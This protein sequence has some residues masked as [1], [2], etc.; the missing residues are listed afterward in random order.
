MIG[1]TFPFGK[2]FL[3]LARYLEH[4]EAG[5]HR[6]RVAWVESRNLPT[7]DP[8]T[9]ARL[10][11][12]HARESVRTQRPVYHFVISFDPGDPVDRESMR[13]VADAV[14]R[15]LGL[16]EHQALIVAHNDTAHPHMHLVVNRV[17]PKTHVAWENSWDWPKIETEL[18]VQE[19]ELGLRR[20]PGHFGRV[21]GR[22]PALALV[23]GDAAFLRS[24]QERAA[25]VLV[26]ARSWAEMQEGLAAAG[27]AVRAK[28][29]GLTIHDGRQEVKASE[30]D[31]AFSRTKM[32]QRFGKWSVRHVE[33]VREVGP[34]LDRSEARAP[35]PERAPEPDQVTEPEPTVARVQPPEPA[36][37][38]RAPLLHGSLGGAVR[39]RL[40]PTNG[41]PAPPAP[42]PVP[43]APPLA[44]IAAPDPEERFRA[45]LRAARE[46]DGGVLP[47]LV[48]AAE[49]AYEAR[50]WFA[51]ETH[52][53]AHLLADEAAK[54]EV[55]RLERMQGRAAYDAARL[56]ETLAGVYTDPDSAAERL[57]AYRRQH[58][59]ERV[60]EALS[61]APERFGELRRVYPWWGLGIKYST[62]AAREEARRQVARPLDS[63]VRSEDA[64]PGAADVAEAKQR[65]RAARSELDAALHKRRA[66]LIPGIA[67]Q[68]AAD[69]LAPLARNYGVD[70]VRRE[71]ARLIPPEDREAAEIAARIVSRAARGL[72]D[73]D[74][75]RG[76]ERGRG[77][78]Y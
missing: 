61:T 62:A 24:V 7:D 53:N 43:S 35:E 78:G 48:D 23:R 52:F 25:P 31:R 51:Y 70:W 15:R 5:E 46:R 59:T 38:I 75:S 65:A 30:V 18:R 10:M 21:P 57:M 47:E 42:E 49:L 72:L 1:R 4:G 19:V 71:L 6:D 64:R 74:R 16:E 58:G 41:P 8:E 36:F 44:A 69:L 12:A 77:I 45:R 17:H 56:R 14:L 28:G 66:L 39:R 13:R 34:V 68:R 2:G 40:V 63:A 55:Q 33:R 50:A 9:A 60:E 29:G 22:E 11:A 54:E 37:P 73:R 27:L 3:G 76:R 32:E 20:V 26:S 67:E